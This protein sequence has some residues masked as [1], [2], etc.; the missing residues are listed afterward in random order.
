[1]QKTNLV[2]ATLGQPNICNVPL[3][4]FNTIASVILK[5]KNMNLTG[6]GLQLKL[7]IVKQAIHKKKHI[8]KI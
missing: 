1:M 5:H 2:Q 6:T 8:N 3:Q 7:H 4:N